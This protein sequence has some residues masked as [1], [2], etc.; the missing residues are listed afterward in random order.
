V[1]SGVRSGI[2]LNELLDLKLNCVVAVPDYKN[3]KQGT[4][5]SHKGMMDTNQA[6]MKAMKEMI[7]A[8]QAKMDA[9]Q[10]R[11]GA[12]QAETKAILKEMK[13]DN[14]EKFEVL[15]GT[16]V[17]RV[18]IHQ[19]KTEATVHSLSTWRRETM[20]CQEMT[21]ANLE[22]KEPTSEDMEPKVEDQKAPK[23]GAA[24]RSSGALKNQHR[25]HYLVAVHHREPKERTQGNCGSQRNLASARRRMTFWPGVA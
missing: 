19:E 25:G 6:E 3:G 8:N 5:E 9:S 20:A 1:T 16:L 13:E 17:F 23:E 15:Q 4:P 7:E 2:G 14:N 11:L 12:I 24:V 21:E 10:A 22:C 18:D